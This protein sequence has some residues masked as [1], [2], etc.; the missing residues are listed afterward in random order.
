[1]CI[2]VCFLSVFRT[3]IAL[4]FTTDNQYRP[5]TEIKCEMKKVETKE[6]KKPNNTHTTQHTKEQYKIM[7]ETLFRSVCLIFSFYFN[8]FCCCCCSHVFNVQKCVFCSKLIS[9]RLFSFLFRV[10]SSLCVSRRYCWDLRRYTQNATQTLT[11]CHKKI[12]FSSFI[13]LFFLVASSS[14]ILIVA[15]CHFYL[16]YKNL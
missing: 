1:M 6:R 11:C 7:D 16:V 9:G 2:S 8:F 14:K 10:I 13:H 3:Y 15:K 4:P 12:L 5:T